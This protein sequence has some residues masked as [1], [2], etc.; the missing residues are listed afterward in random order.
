MS[1][2]SSSSPP[3]QPRARGLAAWLV[4]SVIITATGFISRAAEV[5]LSSR[6]VE[7]QPDP[8]R[9]LWKQVADGRVQL[10]VSSESAFLKS[11]LREL[12][13]PVASQVLV[14]SKTSL[15]R[16]LISPQQPRA[17]Y[18]NDECYVG[19]VKGG[20]IELIG[21]D[22]VEGPKYYLLQRS[23]AGLEK[24]PVFQVGKDC[25]SCHGGAALQVQSVRVDTEGQP[26]TGSV[27]FSITE[28][29]PLGE[30][31][32]GW[33]VTGSSGREAHLGNLIDGKRPLATAPAETLSF[34]LP[35]A[36]YLTDTSDIVALMVLE[37][38]YSTQ[39]ALTE[40]ARAA[41]TILERIT[42]GAESP[43]PE[44]TGRRMLQKHADRLVAKLLFT[45]EHELTGGGVQGSPA[46][47]EAF[48]KSRRVASDG[49]SLRDFELRTRLFKHRCS[50]M[51]HSASFEALPGEFKKVLLQRL[52]LRLKDTADTDTDTD[53][54]TNADRAQLRLILGDTLVL[55]GSRDAP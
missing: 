51:I 14:F 50:Y 53:W 9:R 30:R 24:G 40:T 42:P 16:D 41:R 21:V 38:Q 12:D 29:S 44:S 32:G 25:F 27:N 6:N 28:N 17:I 5:E 10:D 7:N 3:L 52:A 1:R 33:Y 8:V 55:P 11:V 23:V 20:A 49:S 22:A 36:T 37:H 54:L 4:I 13:V 45:E 46:F 34:L 39:N 48:R 19:W 47:Q 15:Q 43:L 26:L 31:W 18:Y 35:K 2:V